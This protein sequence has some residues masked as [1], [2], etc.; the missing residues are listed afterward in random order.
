MR[1]PICAVIMGAL[2]PL[3][4]S[5]Q[6]SWPTRPVTI[7]TATAAGGSADIEARLYAKKLGENT[8]QTFLVDPRPG[9]GGRLGPS[10]VA[11]AQP[12]GNTL[13]AVTGSF[14]LAPALF[15]TLPYDSMKDFAPVSLLTR[16]T[17]MLIAN[18]NFPARNVSEYIAHARANPGK[19]NF[20]TSGLGNPT[21]LSGAWMHDA[22]NT[23]VTF[24]H[25]KG[26][27]YMSDLASGRVDV[28]MVSLLVGLA[29]VKAGKMKALGLTSLERSPLAPDLATVAET[30]K[31]PDFEYPSWF[32]ISAPGRTA[33]G[34]VNRIN[35][36]FVKAVRSPDI[37]H[38]LVQEEG[39]VVVAGTPAQFRQHIA[40]ELGRWPK[41]VR[42]LGISMED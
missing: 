41:M 27:A 36:E 22:T 23:K 17:T 11:K 20:A 13:L 15:R 9:A 1:I 14:T 6:D 12:D 10:V 7:I 18:V 16:R 42:D 29:Q 39:S 25:Y 38:K 34:T 32:G 31:V 19:I 3:A 4:A 30:I 28:G 5:A 40:A 37:S 8:G 21:H 33:A 26:T 35:A 24:V 2:A